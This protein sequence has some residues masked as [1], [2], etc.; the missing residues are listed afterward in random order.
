MVD[1][2][3]SSPNSNRDTSHGNGADSTDPIVA[4]VR[5]MLRD[6]LPACRSLVLIGSRAAPD[7]AVH[8]GA[9]DY[10]L[11]AVVPTLR[12]PFAMPALKRI[13]REVSE[14]HTA[15]I[16]LNPLAYARLRHSKG[17]LM[18][19]K[20]AAEGRVISG[21]NVI[22]L[23]ASATPRSIGQWWYFF[24]IASQAR[25]LL[26]V[27]PHR[28]TTSSTDDAILRYNAAKAVLGC[29]EM[30]LLRS[31][32]YTSDAAAM[33]RELAEAAQDDWAR[34]VRIA[35]GLL[36]GELDWSGTDAWLYA[37][38]SLLAALDRFAYAF[39]RVESITSADFAKAFVASGGKTAWLRDM[40]YLFLAALS[41][42]GLHPRAL[43]DRRSVPERVKL[44]LFWLLLAWSGVGN[45]DP[46]LLQQTRK[47][48]RGAISLP[49]RT[50]GWE[51]WNRLYA[52]LEGAFPA[53]CVALGI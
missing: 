13:E 26:A 48:L 4:D 24:F 33:E 45:P 5:D 20:L 42:S 12:V 9:Q 53:A 6:E 34:R 27:A 30:V 32:I 35:A 11:I 3:G 50:S 14:R 19:L 38:E 51:E 16:T 47:A 22:P 25:R 18:M 7:S 8:A 36:S 28:L 17:N 44:A 40:Q 39:F 29:A 21:E 10:D 37:R 15:K 1:A 41:G 23:A 46:A 2:G 43:L 52:A 31:G 49:K